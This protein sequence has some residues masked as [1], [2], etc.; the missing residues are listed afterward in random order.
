[1]AACTEEK[2]SEVDAKNKAVNLTRGLRSKKPKV[3]TSLGQYK[4]YFCKPCQAWHV[5][6]E[7]PTSTLKREITCQNLSFTPS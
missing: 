5:K 1:M 4:A 7:E 2:L 6:K 3:G